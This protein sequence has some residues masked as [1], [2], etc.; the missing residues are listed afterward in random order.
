VLFYRGESSAEALL[1]SFAIGLCVGIVYGFWQLRHHLRFSIDN[2]VMREILPFAVVG[3]INV[4]SLALIQAPGRIASFHFLSPA[5]A[6]IYS[7]YFT[8]T[9]QVSL[10]LGNM[11]HAVL[12]PVASGGGAQS[13]TWK[14]LKRLGPRTI[15]PLMLFFCAIS[16]SAMLI[17]GSSYPIRPDLIITFSIAASL[18]LLHGV[19]SSLFAARGME[20]LSVSAGGAMIAGLGNL[21]LNLL[22]TPWLGVGGAAAALMISYGAGLG[23]FALNLPREAHK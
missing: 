10:A 16:T 3:T 2:E 6:G 8:A 15:M 12:V 9:A 13:G 11:V 14:T 20:G 19:V 22:L 7:A 1:G 23:W 4:L 5:A 21:G 18:I 17:A